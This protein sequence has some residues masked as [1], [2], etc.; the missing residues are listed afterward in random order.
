M[1]STGSDRLTNY[2]LVYQRKSYKKNRVSID[3]SRVEYIHYW[4]ELAWL[5]EAVLKCQK[6]Q[7]WL[8]LPAACIKRYEWLHFP[9]VTWPT[10]LRISRNAARGIVTHFAWALMFSENQIR[11]RDAAR[12]LFITW[13]RLGPLHR[14]DD[15]LPPQPVESGH[16]PRGG[17][18]QGA[19]IARVDD[20]WLDGLEH[21]QHCGHELGHGPG[22][23]R[24]GHDGDFHLGQLLVF[25]RCGEER[26]KKRRRKVNFWEVSYSNRLYLEKKIPNKNYPVVLQTIMNRSR[27]WCQMS[28]SI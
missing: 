17:V 19:V 12:C 16:E 20:L 23:D 14:W 8:P 15:L 26:R 1:S 27:K 22:D 10:S 21:R 9:S 28:C 3:Y 5:P 13:Q 18:G 25:P 11:K 4:D 2:P 7:K 24:D 6:C